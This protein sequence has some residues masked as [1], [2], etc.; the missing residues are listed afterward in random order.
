MLLKKNNSF[1]LK[2]FFDQISLKKKSLLTLKKK[3]FEISCDDFYLKEELVSVN[4]TKVVFV[5]SI[6]Y[7]PVNT[8]L[9]ISDCSGRLMLYYSA[10]NFFTGKQKVSR[11]LVLKKIFN[12]LFLKFPNLQDKPIAL[13]L[14][15]V[16][17]KSWLIKY[18]KTKMFIAVVK[19][20]TFYPHNGCRN[21]KV[22]RKKYKKKLRVKKE[23]WS[24]GLRRQIVNLLR[25]LIVGSNPAFF[26]LI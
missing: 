3:I 15:N 9:Q 1:N 4:T 8:F 21:K 14:V 5:V 24:S 22:K 18:I 10:G 17:N 25:Y 23:K 19:D 6:R 20:F 2:L 12:N 7:T 13:H 11:F 26:N 16:F